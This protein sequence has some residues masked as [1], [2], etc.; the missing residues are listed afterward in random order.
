M[1]ILGTRIV[2]EVS[3]EAGAAFFFG[4]YDMTPQEVINSYDLEGFVIDK[5][6]V[7]V[8]EYDGEIVHTVH[9]ERGEVAK[10]WGEGCYGNPFNT[11][12]IAF[13]DVTNKLGT[14][15]F[16]YTN[17]PYA[18]TEDD[19]EWFEFCIDY[20]RL[21]EIQQKFVDEVNDLLNTDYSFDQITFV[22]ML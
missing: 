16:A 20:E 18:L 6:V 21:S 10:V 13:L 5:R 3:T 22:R 14:R 8:L 12:G 1:Q 17:S 11:D 15:R 2:D 19:D 7:V 4:Q 9:I